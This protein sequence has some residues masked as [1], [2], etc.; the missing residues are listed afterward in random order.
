MSGAPVFCAVFADRETVR[1]TCHSERKTPDLRR[2]LVLAR[3]AYIARV[4]NRERRAGFDGPPVAVPAIVEAHFEDAGH[5]LKS[6]SPD[7]LVEAAS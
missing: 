5:V 1:M 2:G 6:Y 3:N 7:E 4:H